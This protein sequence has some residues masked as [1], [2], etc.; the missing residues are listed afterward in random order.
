MQYVICRAHTKSESGE[1]H[2]HFILCE[3]VPPWTSEDHK[4]PL[5]S[6]SSRPQ[7]SRQF[8]AD[9]ASQRSVVPPHKTVGPF[10]PNFVHG[11]IFFLWEGNRSPLLQ[12]TPRRIQLLSSSNNDPVALTPEGL[13]VLVALCEDILSVVHCCKKEFLVRVIVLTCVWES[14]GTVSCDQTAFGRK[15][16]QSA[17]RDFASRLLW[18]SSFPCVVKKWPRKFGLLT[19]DYTCG[20]WLTSLLLYIGLQGMIHEGQLQAN[21]FD[22]I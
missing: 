13:S 17:W 5:F 15:V 21:L 6:H 18:R 3:H 1:H 11:M 20:R 9:A 8:L 19:G 10:I 22:M 12:M 7:S 16:Q 14:T 2:L 4:A